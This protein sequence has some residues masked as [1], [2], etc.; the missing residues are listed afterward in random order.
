MHAELGD[1]YHG[2]GLFPDAIAEYEKALRLRPEFPDLHTRLAQTLFDSGLK[3]EAVA[4]LISLKAGQPKYFPGR[5]LL[6]VFL[7]SSGRP[8]EA[9]NEWQE[10]LS[11]DP[12][13]QRAKMYLRL[14]AKTRHW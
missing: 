14:A 13:N 3:D 10:I 11:L 12:E 1:I 8:K 6:G 9:V 2:I 5:I 7:F 4:K